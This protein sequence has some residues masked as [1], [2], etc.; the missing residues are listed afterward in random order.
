M[1]NAQQQTYEEEQQQLRQEY[2]AKP[3][4]RITVPQEPEVNPEVYKD[5]EPMLFRGFI[6]VAAEINKVYF[7]FKN[8]NH[9]EFE[10][11]QFSG[12]VLDR[13]DAQKFWD[14]FLAYGVFMV[15][16]I[17]ILSDRERGVL[18]LVELFSGLPK[19][20][21]AKIIRHISEINRRAS[22]AVNLTEAYAMETTSRYHWMQL[23][24]MDLSS[25]AV[26]GIDGSQRLGLNWAQHLWRALNLAEDRND[27][28]EREWENA[29]FIGSCFAGKGLS[30]IY[31]QD[32]DRRRKEREERFSRKDRLLRMV[33]LGEPITEKFIQIPGATIAGPRTVEELAGQ[34]EKDLRGDKDWHDKVV[35]N[36]ERRVREQYQ[37][38]LQQQEE[39][40][41]SSSARFGDKHITG[42]TDLRGLTQ[43]EVEERIRNAKAY[44]AQDAA[45]MQVF[46][47][48]EKMEKFLNKWGLT[49][50]EISTE[51]SSTNRDTSGAIP[52][53]VR[54]GPTGAPFR[55]K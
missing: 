20:A 7:V 6:T 47:E 49:E 37:A 2:D 25:M 48:D 9:H 54:T 29:K 39:A 23:K 19:E 33:V 18:K 46:P 44:R 28:Y 5:V 12:M 43:Q 52:L 14:I 31:A 3:D 8:L 22:R 4:V 51:V 55:R 16:G 24:G 38:R 53:P 36:H 41:K 15:D 35:E 42:S 1:A 30:K 32:S 10:L 27:E 17:N 26:T 11:L 13:D 34:L 40:I 21:R 45:R 50:P